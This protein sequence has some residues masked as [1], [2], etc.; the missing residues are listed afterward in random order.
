MRGL[1]IASILQVNDVVDKIGGWFSYT[2]RFRLPTKSTAA[3]RYLGENGK[4]V[5][6]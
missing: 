4:H 2:G 5:S 1:Q 3:K 6:N